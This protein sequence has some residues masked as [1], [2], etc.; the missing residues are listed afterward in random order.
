MEAIKR[1]I[2][3]S[4]ERSSKRQNGNTVIRDRLLLG[5]KLQYLAHGSSQARRYM[6]L[7]NMPKLAGAC[8]IPHGAFN[9]PVEA[10]RFTK[11]PFRSNTLT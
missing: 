5:Y 3:R 2:M 11:F 10:K 1:P 9:V 7:L 4:S 6:S 8:T